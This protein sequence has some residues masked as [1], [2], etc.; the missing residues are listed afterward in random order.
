MEPFLHHLTGRHLG[1]FL[2]PFKSQEALDSFI[3]NRLRIEPLLARFPLVRF[4][5]AVFRA[6]AGECI[7]AMVIP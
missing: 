4:D 2:N 6:L 1:S 7:K 3:A 5:E